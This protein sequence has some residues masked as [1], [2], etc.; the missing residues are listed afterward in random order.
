MITSVK[1]MDSGSTRQKEAHI[2]IR[3]ATLAD[4]DVLAHQRASLLQDV[5]LIDSSQFAAL[6]AASKAYFLESLPANEYRAW[7]LECGN[8]IA[9]GGGMI[10]HRLLPRPKD[11]SGGCEAHI[12]N[13]YTEPVFRRQG[14]ARSL[15]TA[16]LSW[17]REHGIN[18]VSLHASDKGRP[19]YRSLG[20]NPTNEM[21]YET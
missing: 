11:H 3:R 13:V 2:C 18:R 12:L 20:F 8:T 14:F 9:A 4:I 5:G 21:R 17:C 19:L 1:H 6:E 7:V 16:M 15:M 10:M